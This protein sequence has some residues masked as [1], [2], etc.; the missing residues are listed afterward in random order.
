MTEIASG[1]A[2]DETLPPEG[3]D[4][5]SSE[6]GFPEAIDETKSEAASD[7]PADSQVDSKTQAAAEQAETEKAH[8]ELRAGEETALKAKTKEAT[9]E[10]LIIETA[11][12][13][14][15]V[16]EEAAGK[17]ANTEKTALQAEQK[18]T[19]V[20]PKTPQE[21]ENKSWFEQAKDVAGQKLA[22]A[23][24]AL[25]S[26]K[27]T[28]KDTAIQTD[29]TLKQ[30]AN[31]VKEQR[32]TN[33]AEV[34]QI[35]A[36]QDLSSEKKQ[37]LVKNQNMNATAKFLGQLA[38][39]T[40]E[41]TGD[42]LNKAAN[43]DVGRAIG[44]AIKGKVSEVWQGGENA[45]KNVGGAISNVQSELGY[46]TDGYAQEF[47][48]KDVKHAMSDAALGAGQVAAD[49]TGRATFGE[50]KQDLSIGIKQ[51]GDDF[52]SA[53]QATRQAI[54]KAVG[55][56]G[57][58]NIKDG[59]TA[60]SNFTINAAMGPGG[61]LVAQ[62]FGKKDAAEFYTQPVN[63]ETIKKN[64]EALGKNFSW[65]NQ[66]SEDVSK[67][68]IGT[69]LQAYTPGA[70]NGL[71]NLTGETAR[72]NATLAENN[73]PNGITKIGGR[74]NGATKAD[75][76]NRVRQG[77]EEQQKQIKTDPNSL[78]AKLDSVN[79]DGLKLQNIPLGDKN[80]KIEI[81]NVKNQEGDKG[82]ETATFS[83]TYK[84]PQT[85]KTVTGIYGSTLEG[86]LDNNA[87]K[88]HSPSNR[89]I[90]I[91]ALAEAKTPQELSSYKHGGANAADA[92]QQADLKLNSPSNTTA[93]LPNHIGEGAVKFDNP[94][95]AIESLTK[96]KE[97]YQKGA[98]EAKNIE[99]SAVDNFQKGRTNGEFKDPV[100]A[101][102]D[103]NIAAYQALKE[104]GT[105]GKA[106]DHAMKVATEDFRQDA[107][108]SF[109][110]EKENAE[111]TR[112]ALN[113]VSDGVI[114]AGN[115]LLVA[116]G[117]GIPLAVALGTVAKVTKD[118][119]IYSE[120]EQS[121]AHMQA[122]R[123]DQAKAAASEQMSTLEGK[124]KSGEISQAA[125]DKTSSNIK[126]SLA[127][128]LAEPKEQTPQQQL[129]SLENDI[130]AGRISPEIAGV[131]QR[132]LQHNIAQTSLDKLKKDFKN[133]DVTLDVLSKES[134][135]LT[136]QLK[137][138]DQMQAQNREGLPYSLAADKRAATPQETNKN[139]SSGAF[140]R[141]TLAGFD[142]TIS[143]NDQ[144]T[145]LNVLGNVTN[146]KPVTQ[147]QFNTALN[148]LAETA[149]EQLK[150]ASAAKLEYLA[151]GYLRNLEVLVKSSQFAKIPAQA[152]AKIAKIA[153]DSPALKKALEA[154][155]SIAPQVT[156]MTTRI[157][158][159]EQL[160]S[161]LNAA[162]KA[163]GK[164]A[165]WSSA[166]AQ[167]ALGSIFAD[168]LTG[169]L[170]E[171]ANLQNKLKSGE[172]SQEQF[173][174]AVADLTTN[175]K[176]GWHEGI[177]SQLGIKNKAF[178]SVVSG[179]TPGVL[180]S[181]EIGLRAGKSPDQIMAD[182]ERSVYSSLGQAG[183]QYG[184]SI[185]AARMEKQ[186]EQNIQSHVSASN[187]S[188]QT[189]AL[190]WTPPA[191]FQATQTQ[192][193]TVEQLQ[194][195]GNIGFYSQS[196]AN[197]A[198]VRVV[199]ANTGEIKS[200]AKDGS[201]KTIGKF[202]MTTVD[203]NPE[204]GT[205][206][207]NQNTR[208][209]RVKGNNKVTNGAP[210]AK[211][212]K[213]KITPEQELAAR[214]TQLKSGTT[215]ENH[216]SP[217]V[218]ST[219]AN[220][221]KPFNRQ[222]PQL[223][224]AGVSPSKPTKDTDSSNPLAPP[225]A[226]IAPITPSSSGSI[227]TSNLGNNN[228][229]TTIGDDTSKNKITDS[230]PVD[231][232]AAAK[233]GKD[234][235]TTS[236]SGFGAAAPLVPNARKSPT[237][238]SAEGIPLNSK[239]GTPVLVPHNATAKDIINTTNEIIASPEMQRLLNELV[240]ISVKRAEY[241]GETFQE[242]IENTMEFFTA[243]IAL[244]VAHT[245]AVNTA[246][247]LFDRKKA[248]EY[249][250]Q[251]VEIGIASQ[252]LRKVFLNVEKALNEEQ[253]PL[254]REAAEK[255]NSFNPSINAF[256][257]PSGSVIDSLISITTTALSTL[258]TDNAINKDNNTALKQLSV[259]DLS[260]TIL[261]AISSF[262]M[263]NLIEGQLAKK[264]TELKNI[265]SESMF[266]FLD[267][268]EQVLTFKSQKG[269]SQTAEEQKAEQQTSQALP[270]SQKA[271]ETASKI[272]TE[273]TDDFAAEDNIVPM[274]SK[275]HALAL[276]MRPSEFIKEL[277]ATNA[278]RALENNQPLSAFQFYNL[279]VTQL[280]TNDDGTGALDETNTDPSYIPGTPEYSERLTSQKTMNANAE[281]F[282]DE[283]SE[284][285]ELNSTRL[286]TAIKVL[287]FNEHGQK[288]GVTPKDITQGEMISL[289]NNL[290]AES[291]A[292][293]GSS[294]IHYFLPDPSGGKHIM[295][296]SGH[297]STTNLK[298]YQVNRVKEVLN[299][300]GHA[301]RILAGSPA[302]Q[303]KIS[304]NNNT[305]PTETL[306][307]ETATNASGGPLNAEV[308]QKRRKTK[309]NGNLGGLTRQD[310]HFVNQDPTKLDSLQ[311]EA[312]RVERPSNTQ[313][314]QEYDKNAA[315]N[316][317]LEK[318]YST[319][320]ALV[321]NPTTPQV[322]NEAV[323]QKS[324]Q[325]YLIDG[326]PARD[327]TQDNV[328]IPVGAWIA[329][330]ND[331]SAFNGIYGHDGGDI[332]IN[333]LST[334]LA[335]SANRFAQMQSQERAQ[336]EAINATRPPA[337]QLPL[338]TPL[339]ILAYRAG[340]DEVRALVVADTDKIA[341]D[342][343]KSPQTQQQLIR[344][345]ELALADFSRL[346]NDEIATQN[347]DP[348]NKQ[349]LP[350]LTGSAMVLK[351]EG[352]KTPLDISNRVN[353][354]DSL[355]VQINKNGANLQ[356]T[357]S[358]SRL[359]SAAQKTAIANANNEQPSWNKGA[360]I[361]FNNTG[362]PTFVAAPTY[363]IEP[364]LGSQDE[365]SYRTA[366]QGL[367]SP[368]GAYEH[369]QNLNDIP[370]S[371]NDRQVLSKIYQNVRQQDFARSQVIPQN[372]NSARSNAATP[373]ASEHL[374]AD[375][376]RKLTK[377]MTGVAD[378][379][380]VA[381]IE[382]AQTIAEQIAPLDPTFRK[383]HKDGLSLFS[384]P[385]GEKKAQE[386]IDQAAQT[387][388]NVNI[389]FIEPRGIN[390][391][392]IDSN[393][394]NPNNPHSSK[395]MHDANKRGYV[396]DPQTSD[397]I[398]VSLAAG[399]AILENQALSAHKAAQEVFG[400]NYGENLVI[401]RDVSK[402]MGIAFS[403]T[404]NPDQITTYLD[405]IREMSRSDEMRP[406]VEV[407]QG[408][409]ANLHIDNHLY[410][411]DIGYVRANVT[412]TEL[413]EPER[414]ITAIRE[415]IMSPRN[416]VDG[417]PSSIMDMAKISADGAKGFDQIPD[418]MRDLSTDG[419]NYTTSTPR[420]QRAADDVSNLNS[421]RRKTPRDETNRRSNEDATRRD[422][423]TSPASSIPQVSDSVL[424][425]Q[426]RVDRL[427]DF[428]K[429]TI[430]RVGEADKGN[431]GSHMVQA[432]APEEKAA[433]S[434]II[435]TQFAQ[436]LQGKSAD[437]Q[438]NIKNAA[439]EMYAIQRAFDAHEKDRKGIRDTNHLN[440]P[441]APLV[442]LS[443]LPKEGY[444]EQAVSNIATGN[445]PQE[446][447]SL[448]SENAKITIEKLQHFKA[449][450]SAAEQNTTPSY[451]QAQFVNIDDV[452]TLPPNK[453]YLSRNDQGSAIFAAQSGIMI[454]SG[455]IIRDGLVRKLDTEYERAVQF[456]A[457]DVLG[458]ELTNAPVNPQVDMPDHM[459]A[460]VARL[461]EFINSATYRMVRESFPQ[462]QASEIR[463]IL[464]E[465]GNA[466]TQIADIEN[467]LK[468]SDRLT[469]NAIIRRF[470]RSG[471]VEA[472]IQDVREDFSETAVF[473]QYDVYERESDG[474]TVIDIK[475]NGTIDNALKQALEPLA[476]DPELMAK[477]RK[478]MVLSA[479]GVSDLTS[480]RKL[481]HTPT[482]QDPAVTREMIDGYV[483]GLSQ[484]YEETQNEALGHSLAFY[485]DVQ[486]KLNPESTTSDN[487]GNNN[488]S[489][490]S[491][492]L[493]APQ[494]GVITSQSPYNF[495]SQVDGRSPTMMMGAGTTSSS[496]DSAARF[497]ER[498]G[499]SPV[500]SKM[501]LGLTSDTRIALKPSFQVG[502]DENNQ[503]IYVEDGF[504]HKGQ[505]PEI[506][507]V[508]RLMAHS[509]I[510]HALLNTH[511]K[512]PQASRGLFGIAGTKADK[513]I[514]QVAE[515]VNTSLINPL[516]QKMGFMDP[517]DNS[518]S[519]GMKKTRE[520]VNDRM[521]QTR[522]SGVELAKFILGGI[523]ITNAPNE[524]I[525]VPVKSVNEAA[526]S[527]AK[528]KIQKNYKDL[529]GITHIE[530]DGSKTEGTAQKLLF[531]TATDEKLI[532][533]G[534]AIA[535]AVA[536]QY[537]GFVEELKREVLH[538]SQAYMSRTENPLSTQE[539][540]TQKAI[541][542][543][544]AHK[545][546][547]ASLEG[548]TSKPA[549][550]YRE[551]YQNNLQKMITHFGDLAPD[552]DVSSTN[553]TQQVAPISAP[554][555][556]DI[557]SQS[558]Y[559]DA[560]KMMMNAG[561]QNT[562]P[563]Q[564]LAERIASSPSQ[565]PIE[566]K[567]SDS[568]DI[569]F[570]PRIQVGVDSN[571]QPTFVEDQLYHEAKEE[572]EIDI[573]PIDSAM[574]HSITT[575]AI[576]GTFVDVPHNPEIMGDEFDKQTS[577]SI[578]EAINTVLSNAMFNQFGFT[579]PDD[580][581]V[582][583]E[584]DDIE[585]ALD[586]ETQNDK[587]IL[588]EAIERSMGITN[589]G[590]SVNLQIPLEIVDAAYEQDDV[591][592]PILAY[593]KTKLAYLDG[594]VELE[595]D[596]DQSDAN[597]GKYLFTL[598][599][600]STLVE[601]ANS[602][603]EKTS[604]QYPE[605]ISELKK[606]MV[607]T[608]DQAYSLIENPDQ[609]L[610]P[611]A[612][613]AIVTQMVHKIIIELLE[614]QHGQYATQHR[615]FYQDNLQKMIA[616]FGDLAPDF[617][618][619]S[620][621][622]TQ[623]SAPDL[624]SQTATNI[625]S[626][627][628]GGTPQMALQNSDVNQKAAQLA[629]IISNGK[630]GNQDLQLIESFAKSTGLDS[631]EAAQIWQKAIA[632]GLT[633]LG[634]NA[635]TQNTRNADEKLFQQFNIKMQSNVEVSKTN[636]EDFP[637]RT[638]GFTNQGETADILQYKAQAWQN[639]YSNGTPI[640]KS[641][642]LK[643]HGAS[644]EALL[645]E[646]TASHTALEHP[647]TMGVGPQIEDKKLNNGAIAETILT[648]INLGNYNFL[649]PYGD[650]IP[651]FTQNTQTIADNYWGKFFTDL[652]NPM[653]EFDKSFGSVKNA[654]ALVNN[655]DFQSAFRQHH[656]EVG[657]FLQNVVSS[658]DNIVRIDGGETLQKSFTFTPEMTARIAAANYQT[659]R[660]L[661]VYLQNLSPSEVSERYKD[662]VARTIQESQAHRDWYQDF[663]KTGFLGSENAATP[664]DITS[665]YTGG[666]PQASAASTQAT[667]LSP[668]DERRLVDTLSPIMANL[669]LKEA[670]NKL[671]PEEQAD[672]T[673]LRHINAAKPASQ[674]T[675]QAPANTNIPEQRTAM[676][677]DGT[678]SQLM[679]AMA[680]RPSSDGS[681]PDISA[682]YIMP[683][684]RDAAK[685]IKD[686]L[687]QSVSP[688]AMTQS[689]D[690]SNE[691]AKKKL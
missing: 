600:T 203:V 289:L 381:D 185:H 229:D 357:A 623:Q 91:V 127:E 358:N 538:N 205:I 137:T 280:S 486:Q 42:L 416:G 130:A 348:N 593:A 313:L 290:G 2:I 370:L 520:A 306:T 435:D 491:A 424:A 227:N 526:I 8:K 192:M 528:E 564:S 293:T 154:A 657:G 204:N 223:V 224:G 414:N 614:N 452:P 141:E 338:P 339:K 328:K 576:L 316:A 165:E 213:E 52:N 152:A 494:S 320:P 628:T 650:K 655:P 622:N 603:I 19:D 604:I 235:T 212:E 126:K 346:V 220:N 263:P 674:T 558:P 131:Q 40:T 132:A 260:N 150:T 178:A 327:G 24:E 521:L 110:S 249:N 113:A 485:R 46:F 151:S 373:A 542:T 318:L 364:V 556:G 181:V 107:N 512:I 479:A 458:H 276:G 301:Q 568:G 336:I 524:R 570:R 100:E 136:E 64:M 559:G 626:Q 644:L 166:V 15:E 340:G 602:L 554:Q 168:A 57:L 613:K 376:S 580:N 58:Q 489:R 469:S 22:Q 664:N 690:Q 543:Q 190:Q 686:Q 589:A 325:A 145:V 349:P 504:K 343:L 562:Q 194:S 511:I 261:E 32:D 662:F 387:G 16:K 164:G 574:D 344:A 18:A 23:G 120:G 255:V 333:R 461:S 6:E 361:I 380:P 28:L 282:V 302:M 523:S 654:S 211:E 81:L 577:S 595:I 365:N 497:Q 173:D 409:T 410:S 407:S 529:D 307:T 395:G 162:A 473:N 627:Y 124:L 215:D 85:G 632:N 37:E 207:T 454:P 621:N 591:D 402:R 441:S 277:E 251:D 675:G 93:Q 678:P 561:S 219:A 88:E 459:K 246:K 228:N 305:T 209:T 637:P 26:A 234:G 135:A 311:T 404:T 615:A 142:P 76:E 112:G 17:V 183:K 522:D 314:S 153:E 606:Q 391:L 625:T 199:D 14:A 636:Q 197:S 206:S 641:V 493:N 353:E 278:T 643:E 483:N 545:M 431:F 592:E 56:K 415:T 450:S 555:S 433:V 535:E 225:S 324:L 51:T 281:R 50:L 514:S 303:T 5:A 506:K 573:G 401:Y 505:D 375:L 356:D 77:L 254:F 405:R 284:P 232:E 668:T 315:K 55:E 274:Q 383:F 639:F 567:T 87:V 347:A 258:A 244:V 359:L 103:R 177:S 174:R 179:L 241:T 264:P 492:P 685:S 417:K 582:S 292:D 684:Y 436:Q 584:L 36:R 484:L 90:G 285:I 176:S 341:P 218:R 80:T 434:K 158:T 41:G 351:P 156:A 560:F 198:R 170:Q 672:L 653:I 237:T 501:K 226:P 196:S 329:D 99:L 129:A 363:D 624:M 397:K 634:D 418:M 411:T 300:T 552:F 617:D 660:D 294:H 464:Q 242:T 546:I 635:S 354:L 480:R 645:N 74:E 187:T 517:T 408:V 96:A 499:N 553:N 297:S 453:I 20:E 400:E 447:N 295:T 563:T 323:F 75:V 679:G 30:F 631:G 457:H 460:P 268:I 425:A 334:A 446:F 298:E 432:I 498:L 304:A 101:M 265:A 256:I 3:E 586:M 677:N 471:E 79:S 451:T 33:Q 448:L 378:N 149:G 217:D 513:N 279:K 490:T 236:G 470:A 248:Q 286:N 9:Q 163:A 620:T 509:V 184:Q 352:I 423:S 1:A 180:S 442:Q 583:N 495:S 21:T 642:T 43:T 412:P 310:R 427:E 208:F 287:G 422:T 569:G 437:D 488:D 605:L 72:T 39:A 70:T 385:A 330:G 475:S 61:H 233:G 398:P 27:N 548:Q 239:T 392:E 133:G 601:K 10:K 195:N 429:S 478:Q 92:L 362:E 666:T 188:S 48:Y 587:G 161:A 104:K 71:K 97:L 283:V 661:E 652:N 146:G 201:I 440:L 271:T 670:K 73:G 419:I 53:K 393:N 541:V 503:P 321:A 507:T 94:Q 175:I 609:D 379:S 272:A 482:P 663:L 155:Q 474:Q 159:S 629:Q 62:A 476:N 571:G 275:M 671:T 518:K 49:L 477:L 502:I 243:K 594:I 487:S 267:M 691:E 35:N 68:P 439:F 44:G 308:S 646:T 588:S 648:S 105:K 676:F 84:D 78:A 537:P 139:Q 326:L 111:K 95:D 550:Q 630:G 350:T 257:L 386:F 31:E 428:V 288:L 34:D 12:N 269:A 123:Q 619:S 638:Y 396:I 572:M 536:Q 167:E 389:A 67:N 456:I 114:M 406:K 200:I 371:D 47:G 118:A 143:R 579:D 266:N 465:S 210:E 160:K 83:V 647:L 312:Q 481:D 551:F 565:Y 658:P 240:D 472:S 557:S 496:T 510:T 247:E 374:P 13:K 25:E 533:K 291:R 438:S 182:V 443:A 681:Q 667:P 575:H 673:A 688:K 633:P 413:S 680:Y 403:P 610:E 128:Q 337:E 45:V 122:Y 585:D 109:I 455:D 449:P 147:E 377:E 11:Q 651:Q 121:K 394:V 540:Y 687:I 138:I 597:S 590:D 508:D 665:Q 683:Q 466:E 66:K 102:F 608:L 202:D 59:A 148:H 38:G 547:I 335:S 171:A 531:K 367:I 532:K 222:E 527:K 384:R 69:F 656:M 186:T 331:F 421:D 444:I 60:T 98:K 682:I 250:G 134:R 253:K 581:T 65:T 534:E 426:V 319:T 89:K 157:A 463:Q 366:Q 525:E 399:D 117:A 342:A 599:P 231:I 108:T 467:I 252:E 144:I 519:A 221:I 382:N 640:G 445:S 29:S 369:N 191:D 54:V 689:L 238:I 611:V 169:N 299:Y 82:R 516:F 115:G 515:A 649:M 578:S 172:L 549:Q 262:M 420:S 270:T 390:P 598:N 245:H 616:S 539:T 355:G 116:S 322:M 360:I 273:P 7:Q 500:G 193:A 530:Y 468:L 63:N 430:S 596:H 345:Q 125:F 140:A 86:R 106:L 669:L 612:Q 462:D 618:V 4:V 372:L 189:P 214:I 607:S 230:K 317:E 309:D 216:G 544:I 259:F 296:F 368:S 119:A 388:E 332:G 566:F 659:A